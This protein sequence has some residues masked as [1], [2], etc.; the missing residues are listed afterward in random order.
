MGHSRYL[1]TKYREQIM[2]V[3]MGA[4]TTLISWGSYDLFAGYLHFEVNVSNILSWVCGVMFAFVVN[5]WVVFQSKSTEKHVI[6]REFVS[7]IG[8]RIFTGVIAW[9]LFP[10]LIYFN[11][12]KLL[13]DTDGMY[14]KIIT[15][16]V[17]IVLNWIL[18]KYY[19][20]RMKHEA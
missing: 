9:I 17:E 19:V 1:F 10:I 12:D 15:S 18:S 7:F 4:F 5:K 14:A 3:I 6:T 20:F 11:I 2:Y 16:L 8:S 13:I